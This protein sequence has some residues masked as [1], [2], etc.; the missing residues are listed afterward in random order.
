MNDRR[1]RRRRRS[2]NGLIDILNGL[3]TLL[4]I[5]LVVVGGG[6]FYVASQYYGDGPLREDRVFRVESGNTLST[7]ANRLEEQGFITNSVIFSQFGSRVEESA[8]IKAGDFNIPAGASMSEILKE[9]TL[10][11]PL[12]YAVTIPEGWTVWQAIQ[13]INAD[14]QLTGSIDQLPPE[15][16]LLPGSYDYTPGDTRQSVLEA[17]QLAMTKALAEVWEGREADLPLESPAELLI[18]ASIVEKETGIASERPQIAAVFVNRIREGMRLQSDPTIIYGITLGQATLDRGIRRSEIEE[19]TP[20]NTYQIDGLPP[21]PIANPGIEAL[22]AVAHP[23]S[24]DYLYFVAKGATPR[25]GHVFAETYAEHQQNV[26]RYREIAAEAAAQA[27]AEAEA[28]RQ[29]LEA[30]EAEGADT[31]AEGE[32]AQ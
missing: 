8:V 31:A 13:R 2:G 4:V 27:E 28:A 29:A 22:Q 5:G 26:A 16:S 23:D 32:T 1:N 20:Y 25:E 10:G 15:G 18:L 12:R 19:K 11:N 21:T 17:M 3:L 30:Q 14:D 24:H 9:L 7:T 6:L